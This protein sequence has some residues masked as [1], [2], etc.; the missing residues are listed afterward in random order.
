MGLH[1]FEVY[2][3]ILPGAQANYHARLSSLKLVMIWTSRYRT[4]F[5]KSR[6]DGKCDIVEDAFASE[7]WQ[8][9]KPGKR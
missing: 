7:G 5:V 3:L 1:S 4:L 9:E 2:P 8:A 6:A